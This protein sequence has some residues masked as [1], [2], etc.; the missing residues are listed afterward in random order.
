MRASPRPRPVKPLVPDGSFFKPLLWARLVLTNQ[1]RTCPIMECATT[2]PMAACCNLALGM[3]SLA[4]SV[5]GRVC[6]L[7]GEWGGALAVEFDDQRDPL[8]HSHKFR[9]LTGTGV[10]RESCSIGF[11]FPDCTLRKRGKQKDSG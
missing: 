11:A 10:R 1:E 2:L 5:R 6:E 7:S 9:Q 8:P 4:A 3:R